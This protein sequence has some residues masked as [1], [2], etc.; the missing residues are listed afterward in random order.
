MAVDE[1]RLRHVLRRQ[2]GVVTAA[3]A[4]ELGIGRSNVRDRIRSDRW[5]RIAPRV[6]LSSDREF[7]DEVRLRAAVYSAGPEATAHGL[8][9]AW[10]HRLIPAMPAVVDVTV[11]RRCAPTPRRGVQVRRRDLAAADRVEFRDLWVTELPLTVLEAAVVGPD[12]SALLDRAL[13]GRVS[14]SRLWAAHRRNEGRAGSAA[15]ARL[16]TAAAD[17][18]ASEAERVLVRLLRDAGITGWVLGYRRLS[19]VLDMGRS[20]SGGWR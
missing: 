13:Q 18:A 9:A 20:P 3:Q 11:P 15:A 1:P 2:S 10:W 19:Y 6:Y 16:L 4:A 17:G 8:S 14:L 12:G 7:T 5:R